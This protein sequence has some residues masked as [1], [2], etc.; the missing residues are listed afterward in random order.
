MLTPADAEAL[1]AAGWEIGFHTRR[2]DLLTALG[3]DA[4]RAAIDRPERARSLAYPHGKAA[5]R[6]AAAARAA[7]Y[8]AAY[9]GAPVALTA[10]TDPQLI[11]RLQP[12]TTSVGRFALDLARAVARA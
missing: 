3:E 8:E 1:A 4:L 10:R 11:G 2:H 9:T 7:G 5:S 6:E 12:R